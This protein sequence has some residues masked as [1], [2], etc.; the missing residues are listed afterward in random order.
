MM[1][2]S[3]CHPRH[4]DGTIGTQCPDN[5]FVTAVE[6]SQSIDDAACRE[7]TGV[8]LECARF[9]TPL[10]ELPAVKATGQSVL[11]LTV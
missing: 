6:L 3:A 4:A 9:G 11:E 7:Q 5:M 10:L 2:N 8:M 1:R